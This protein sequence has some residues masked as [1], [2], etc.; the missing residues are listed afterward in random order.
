MDHN[1]K[2]FGDD[3]IKTT[4]ADRLTDA[5]I[6]G[7]F[8]RLGRCNVE[9]TDY[10]HSSRSAPY[11]EIKGEQNLKYQSKTLIGG[12]L[13]AMQDTPKEV[14][15]IPLFESG[16]PEIQAYYA[17]TRQNITGTIRKIHLYH[18]DDAMLAGF[19]FYDADGELI[20][21]SA[22]KDVFT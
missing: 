17:L 11:K 21:E 14:E 18:A 6:K 12:Q 8:E 1:F 2:Q 4:L 10:G 22:C 16:T 5:E 9:M 7:N 13:I 19:R 20:Y 15:F 3:E